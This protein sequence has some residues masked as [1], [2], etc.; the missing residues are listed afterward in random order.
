MLSRTFAPT[1]KTKKGLSG[2]GPT[3]MGQTQQHLAF[4][5]LFFKKIMLLYFFLELLFNF[6]LD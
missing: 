6:Y 1:T 3:K 2:A 5:F 4:T